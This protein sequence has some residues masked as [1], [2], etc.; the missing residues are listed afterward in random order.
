MKEG[1]TVDVWLGSAATVAVPDLRGL[2]Q[3]AAQDS[4]EA[5]GLILQVAGTI[6]TS[7]SMAGRVVDQDPIS[8]SVATGSTIRVWIGEA[9]NF[10]AQ[11]TSSWVSVSITGGYGSLHSIGDPVDL[12]YGWAE[13]PGEPAGWWQVWDN[14]PP[15]S[16]GVILREGSMISSG[17]DC[18]S[19][20]ITGPTGY[21]EIVIY[22]LEYKY[23]TDSWE[24]KGWA[25]VYIYV[26]E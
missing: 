2:P 12:C 4:V 22:A 5:A 14:Q 15:E 1:S 25:N 7:E 9:I 11:K 3:S 13:L 16:S 23:A 10:P 17:T 18:F 26:T 24:V 6:L 21:E 8:G 19:A 20:T